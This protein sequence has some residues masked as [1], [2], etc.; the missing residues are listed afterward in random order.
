MA[1]QP[2]RRDDSGMQRP[3][4]RARIV[5]PVV[6]ASSRRPLHSF[7]RLGRRFARSEPRVP[8]APRARTA[9]CMT[10]GSPQLVTLKPG[11]GR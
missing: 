4:G 3:T 8:R 9:H 2:G 11:G 6:V 1:G 5:I 10:N 7:K